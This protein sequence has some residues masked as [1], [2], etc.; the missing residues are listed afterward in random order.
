[1]ERG[2]KPVPQNFEILKEEIISKEKT[3]ETAVI[4]YTGASADDPNRKVAF[5]NAGLGSFEEEVNGI[6]LSK[7]FSIYGPLSA[8]QKKRKNQKRSDANSSLLMK[9]ARTKSADNNQDILPIIRNTKQL[10]G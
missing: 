5:G 2:N 6:N 9:E 1:M 7:L 3:N 8:E 10:L 4:P